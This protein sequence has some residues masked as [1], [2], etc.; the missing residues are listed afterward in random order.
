MGETVDGQESAPPG[1]DVRIPDLARMYDYAL[2]GRF[3]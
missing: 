3:R 1:I 2:G